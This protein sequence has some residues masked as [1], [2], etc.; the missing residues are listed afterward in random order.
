M[1]SARLAELEAQ[2]FAVRRNEESAFYAVSK[3]K[4]DP[5]VVKNTPSG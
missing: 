4:A 5:S 3:L 2:L 1:F